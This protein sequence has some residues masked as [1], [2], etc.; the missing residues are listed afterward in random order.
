M[1]S[2]DS[3]SSP[4][5]ELSFSVDNRTNSILASGTREQLEVVEAIILRLDAS[6]IEERKTD[7]YRLKNVDARDVSSSLTDLLTQQQQVT[8]IQEGQ[9]LQQQLE[10]EVII[11]PEPVS[12]SLL[13]SASARFYDRVIQ[14]VEK[15]DQLPPQVLIQVLLVQVTLDSNLEF[16]VELGLQ[17]GILFNRSNAT[18]GTIVQPAAGTTYFPDG[19]IPGYNFN[20]TG[21]LGNNITAANPSAIGNQGLTNLGLGRSSSALG[22]GGLVLS[23]SSG[24]RQCSDSGGGSEPSSRSSLSSTDHDAR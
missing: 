1:T 11:V 4:L 2:V 14:L 5:V 18:S 12:N 17:D 10:R 6:D 21:P 13:I 7:V 9:S 20:S 16:G 8:G 23:A 22:Y 24:K 3:E 15:L 19:G